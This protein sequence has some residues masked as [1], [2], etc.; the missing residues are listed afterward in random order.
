MELL[1]ILGLIVMSLLFAFL[2]WK[3]AI[4]WDKDMHHP[5]FFQLFIGATMIVLC[6]FHALGWFIVLVINLIN[7]ST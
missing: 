5:K 1:S 6:S 4:T 3:I 7:L 2:G